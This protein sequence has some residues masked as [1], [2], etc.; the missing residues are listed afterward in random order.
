[1]GA[2]VFPMGVTRY[3]PQKA[4]NGYTLMPVHGIGAVLIDMNGN[5]VKTWTDFLG[6]PN[7]LLPGGRVMGSLGRR[8]NQYGYQDMA[9]LTQVSWEG[10]VEW[11]FSGKEELHD[12]DRT[13]WMARQ[14]HDY[15]REGNP[16]G[17]YVSGMEART[18][19]GS[20]LILCH[21]DRFNKRISDKRLLDDCIIEVDWEGRIGWKWCVSEHFNEL[22]FSEAAKNVLFRNP[23]VHENGGG[24]SDWMHINSMSKLGPNRW[25]EAGDERFDPEN[26][27]WDARESNIIA[28]ISRRTG[29]LV[30]KLGP[31]Y[32]AAKE[33]RAIGQIIG[34][35][36]VH[37]I[38]RG[39]PGE[40][41]LLIFDNGG[42][43]GYGL[44]SRTSKDGTKT[45]LRDH[46]RVLE[47][48][49]RTLKVVWEFDGAVFGGMMDITARS[50]FYSP[51]ISSAQRLPNGNTLID[52][53]C[54]CRMLEVTPDREV[55]WEYLAPFRTR[56][57][58]IYRAYRYPY[59]YVPQLVQPDETPVIPPDNHD[60]RVPGAAAGGIAN[61]TSV[62][63]TWGVEGSMDACVTDGQV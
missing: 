59:S 58:Y 3:N 39:L 42:W 2:S 41:N 23:N 55:V 50:Q 33:T 12:G 30:W 43:A 62:E 13:L 34:Q 21:E 60:F 47:L 4:W 7:K 44:P 8:E 57:P 48:N 19:S 6:F 54:S 40:G 38:P 14:H 9:D 22:G 10:K 45:D 32:T 25:F 11:T 1:M 56:M 20:T 61:A 36:H 28:I 35:H 5:V 17:Y 26:I 29:K 16:V 37:M 53:G 31:D 24:Q 15:Q 18:D 52:E 46:S 27:I 63:G 51:L 49:P